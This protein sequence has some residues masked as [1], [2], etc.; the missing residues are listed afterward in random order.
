[1]SVYYCT[2]K[3]GERLFSGRRM[4]ADTRSVD[5]TGDGIPLRQYFVRIEAS[6]IQEATIKMVQIFGANWSL[7]YQTAEGAG[8]E[9]FNL[10]ELPLPKEIK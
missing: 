7:C 5:M 4:G 1:M 6:D 8:V 2:F 3:N 10:I 9:E